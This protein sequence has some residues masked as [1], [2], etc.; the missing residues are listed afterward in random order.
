MAGSS[1]PTR[2]VVEVVQL[3]TRRA[4]TPIRLSDIVHELG[5]NQATASA[6]LGELVTAGW[7]DRDPATKTYSV[8]N[9]L[10]DLAA[11]ISQRP[12]GRQAAEAVARAM[13]AHSRCAV[14]VSERQGDQLV[15]TTFIRAAEGVDDPWRPTVGGR[16]PYAAP[17]GPAYAAWQPLPEQRAWIERGGARDEGLR[18]Q[19]QQLLTETRTRGYSVESIN[20]EVVEAV[21]VMARL[22]SEALS[23]SMRVHLAEVLIEIAGGPVGEGTARGGRP[24]YVGAITAPFF[25]GSHRVTHNVSVHPFTTLSERRIAQIGRRVREEARA[26]GG[27]PPP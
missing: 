5:L 24:R 20:P 18:A 14:S 17:F 9:A 15:I 1:P 2:R 10:G 13:A 4:G 21:P 19:L 22:Q 6:V 26:A 12:S 11:Q 7:V 27:E 25:D 8:G 16:L 23:E 3:I